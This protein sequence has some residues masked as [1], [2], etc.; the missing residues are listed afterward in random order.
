MNGDR[1]PDEKVG[2]LLDMFVL[3][4][5]VEEQWRRQWHEDHKRWLVWLSPSAID[6]LT[7]D[8]LRERFL[9]YYTHGAGRYRWYPVNRDKLVKD[10]TLLRNTLKFLLD[11]NIDIGKKLH[12]TLGNGGLHAIEGMGRN[13]VTSIF[14]DLDPEKYCTW[15]TKT[16]AG[17]V[18]LGR[19]PVFGKGDDWGGKYRKVVQAL[20][21]IRQ[22][23]Q[24]LDFIDVDHFMHI[25]AATEEG[26]D[27]VDALRRGDPPHVQTGSPVS[28]GYVIL[29]NLL[30]E[31]IVSN[32]DKVDFGSK[33]DLYYY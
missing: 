29:E 28:G 15:N 16:Q 10:V 9:E 30:E 17:L 1:L 27:A 21:Q 18:Q 6:T 11:E 13:L 23:R 22:L 7:D 4:G 24:G 5:E 14:E 32:F 12:E 33:L 3:P 2:R 20:S 8:E 26:M 25:V 31:F 19:W